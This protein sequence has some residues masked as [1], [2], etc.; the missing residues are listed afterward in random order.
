MNELEISVSTPPATPVQNT[1]DSKKPVTTQ[2]GQ[3]IKKKTTIEVLEHTPFIGDLKANLIS[4]VKMAEIV[5]SLFAPAFKDY[6]GCKLFINNGNFYN[7]N[8]N[9]AYIIPMGAIYVDLYFS[10]NG[11]NSGAIKNLVLKGAA[12]DNSVDIGSRFADVANTNS[13]ENA[14]S[15]YNVTKETYEA[16]EEFMNARNIRWSDYTTEISSRTNNYGPKEQATVRISGLNLDRILTKIYGT[17]SNEQNE[18]EYCATPSTMIPYMNGEFVMTVYQL[19]TRSVR[20]LYR[21]INATNPAS[22]DFHPYV[23]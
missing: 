13:M 11:D 6:V 20:Q 19:N 17:G 4:S 2:N 8:P 23:R 18:Y 7:S 16:L 10:D 21:E 3:P 9:V 5:S 22:I 15:I 14:G 1:E 12:K